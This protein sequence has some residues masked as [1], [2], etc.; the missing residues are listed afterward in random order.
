[1]DFKF[2]PTH[3]PLG[4]R[5]ETPTFTVDRLWATMPTIADAPTD[6]SD[7]IDR[8]YRYRSLRELRWHLADRFDLPVA[9]IAL[10]RV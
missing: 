7:R 4:L 10:E 9:A 8:T 1:M 5:A 3:G 2:S 6:V